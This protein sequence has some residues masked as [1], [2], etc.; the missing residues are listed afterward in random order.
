M[1]D[2]V[3]YCITNRKSRRIYI[4]STSDVKRRQN[5]HMNGISNQSHENP[6][7]HFDSLWCPVDSWNFKVISSHQ[8]KEEMLQEEERLIRRFFGRKCSY[9]VSITSDRSLTNNVYILSTDGR[10]KL[11][12]SKQAILKERKLSNSTFIELTSGVFE[13]DGKIAINPSLIKN[14][15]AAV[16]S[17]ESKTNQKIF[18]KMLTYFNINNFSIYLDSS[19]YGDFEAKSDELSV[20]K[21]LCSGEIGKNDLIDFIK[22]KDIYNR[23]D[24]K[25]T[26]GAC[27]GKGFIEINNK[28]ISISKKGTAVLNYCLNNEI[29]KDK[30]AEKIKIENYRNLIDINIVSDVNPIRI[31]LDEQG[32]TSLHTET[33][34][35]N[36]RYSSKYIKFEV[37]QKNSILLLASNFGNLLKIEV[38][39]EAR[40]TDW[41]IFIKN[42]LEPEEVINS[43]CFAGKNQTDARSIVVVSKTGFIGSFSLKSIIELS[44]SKFK[45]LRLLK[46]D[47]VYKIL[48][49]TEYDYIFLMTHRSRYFMFSTN[50]IPQ[51][52]ISRK[53]YSKILLT[54]GEFMA[55]AMSIPQVESRILVITGRGE[56]LSIS[57]SYENHWHY[58]TEGCILIGD[59]ENLSFIEA[60]LYQTA[61]F[62]FEKIVI[63]TDLGSEIEID[64][65]LVPEYKER[66][67][68]PVPRIHGLPVNINVINAAL[69]PPPSLDIYDIPTIK[70]SPLTFKQ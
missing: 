47:S 57:N 45:L 43:F 20:M 16:N 42:N 12:G 22:R 26:L 7:I 40:I 54:N 56:L 8:T 27:L 50:T 66:G 18:K 70:N 17:I 9:N 35:N 14:I 11:F 44:P 69:K 28:I 49:S 64:M 34:S 1:S 24:H 60:Y 10:F 4:G 25:K 33:A 15:D 62:K 19:Q 31:Y 6:K 67:F 2:Y 63:Y 5:S 21:V 38:E 58:D 55:N 46:N 29:V 41:N 61:F 39:N 51:G 59:F 48:S 65:T 53:L 36:S 32:G 13:I 52:S 37:F 23:F 3:V 30:I 68:K